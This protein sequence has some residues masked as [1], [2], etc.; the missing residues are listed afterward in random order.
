ME[1]KSFREITLPLWFKLPLFVG[2]GGGIIVFLLSLFSPVFFLM[3][4][5]RGF[6][7]FLIIFFEVLLLLHIFSKYRLNFLLFGKDVKVDLR[8]FANISD[9]MW[10]YRTR[11]EG[12]VSLP[13]VDER[14]SLE[15]LVSEPT[16]FGKTIEELAELAKKKPDAIAKVVKIMLEEG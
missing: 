6:F 3:A 5:L 7:A 12:E 15:R 10:I 14:S 1:L 8:S 9:F 11:K 4:L 16:E 2:L 13:S